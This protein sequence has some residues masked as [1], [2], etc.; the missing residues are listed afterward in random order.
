M[1]PG[2]VANLEASL[3]AAVGG[4][5]ATL[6]GRATVGLSQETWFATIEVAGESRRVVLRMPT[7]ASGARS[8]G[9]QRAALELAHANAVPVPGVLWSSLGTDN[10]LGCPFLVME[11]IDG[12][13]PA[14]W[15]RLEPDRRLRLATDAVAILTRVHNIDWTTTD[16]S[17]LRRPGTN[18]IHEE[19]AFYRR[20]FAAL[21][22]TAD[23]T[24]E[25]ALRRLESRV[26]VLDDLVVSHNDFRMGNFVVDGDS[27][28]SVL[29]WELAAIGHPAADL[30]WCFIAVW[31]PVAID[32]A[33]L[34][35]AY[36]RASGRTLDPGT[37]AFFTALGY[38]RL[39]YYALAGGAAF[40]DGAS[41]DLRHAALRFEVPVRLDRLFCVLDELPVT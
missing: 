23:A 30:A 10:A 3:A 31:E 6:E 7:A 15:N 11:R 37:V 40:M 38:L 28:V 18:G 33:R 14:G 2:R 34:H 26:P 13:I 24:I 27:I 1:S 21:G 4:T 8:I 35:A 5:R 12:E 29:D 9:I 20:R 22:S 36:E 19:L 16:A 17:Q 41:D 25:I 39:V 32:L